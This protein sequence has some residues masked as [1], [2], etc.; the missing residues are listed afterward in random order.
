[1]KGSLPP[2]LTLISVVAGLYVTTG[3]GRMTTRDCVD[4]YGNRRPDADCTRTGVG[5]M[6]Y[7]RFI[8]GG[9]TVNGRV[10]GGSTTMP[11]S[12]GIQTRNGTVIRSA[13]FGSGS[14]YSS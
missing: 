1:M 10:Y 12:G 6:Y 3:C 5:G 2:Q 4:Q 13:G 7:P 14:S 8:Y 11:S 9:N